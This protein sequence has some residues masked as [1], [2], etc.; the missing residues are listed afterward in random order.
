MKRGRKNKATVIVSVILAVVM[1]GASSFAVYAKWDEISA[2]IGLSNSAGTQTDMLSTLNS[3]ATEENPVLDETNKEAD[4][5]EDK[6]EVVIF[7]RP[8]YMRASYLV[9]GVDFL[10]GKAKNVAAIKEEIDKAISMTKGYQFNTI[11][12]PVNLNLMKYLPEDTSLQ[13]E[14]GSNFDILNYIT[15]KTAENEL[16]FYAVYDLKS[17][18]SE[19]GEFVTVKEITTEQINSIISQLSAFAKTYKP[20]GILLDNY[21]NEEVDTSYET[22]RKIGGGI[23]Y[24]NWLQEN[25]Y[26]LVKVAKETLKESNPAHQVGILA[27]GVW[28]NKQTN[29][30]GSDT[31]SSFE[32]LKNGWADTKKMIQNKLFDFAMVKNFGSLTN[33]NAPFET[34]AA[35]W[36]AIAKDANIPFYML[37]DAS[38]V[39]T[40]ETGWKNPDQL[41]RQAITVKKY[42]GF[43]GSAYLNLKAFG[44]NPKGSSQALLNYYAGET[45]ESYLFR[46]LTLY[47]PKQTNFVTYE[48]RVVFYGITDPNFE[49]V[50]NGKTMK[51]NAEGDFT[52]VV[53]L[54][55]GKNTITFEHKG[56]T[57]TYTITRRVV[58]LRDIA[59]LGSLRVTGESKIEINAT[60]YKGATVTA[61]LG[62]LSV[63]LQESAGIDESDSGSNYCTFTGLLT[64]PKETAVDQNLG[65]IIVTATWKGMTDSKQGAFVLV[66]KYS[67]PITGDMVEVSVEQAETYPIDVY[68]AFCDPTTF[69][70]AKGTIDYIVGDPI[71]YTYEGV[72][73][74]FVNLKSGKRVE[75]KEIRAIEN[76]NYSNN[77]IDSVT[78]RQNGQFTEV[79]FAN[80]WKVPYSLDFSPINYYSGYYVSSYQPTQM[81]ITIDYTDGICNLPSFATSPLFSNASWSL[82]TENGV[83]K[84]KLTVNLKKAGRFFGL[85]PIYDGNNLILR[86]NNPP[87]YQSA[88][89]Q[90]GATLVGTKIF[91]D[92]GHGA[93]ESCAVWQDKNGNWIREDKLNR[94]FTD[95]IEAILKSLGA[96][97]YKLDTTG[98]PISIFDRPLIAAQWKPNLYLSLHN[99][100]VTGNSS[101]RGSVTFY[102]N[103]FSKPL[104]NSL[105]NKINPVLA[106]GNYGDRFGR[107]RVIMHQNFPGS[108]IEFGFG[109]NQDELEN[110]KNPA[111]QQKFAEKVVEA[112]VEYCKNT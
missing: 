67:P 85:Y 65:N 83:S 55:I 71:K 7:K 111:I 13:N 30:S 80:K 31:K 8:D 41:S 66:K 15:E 39:C 91:L 45:D 52:E 23:G 63:N 110:L 68:N 98:S 36:D 92:P 96:T 18:V 34:V 106:S 62:G 105:Y 90:Y 22:Y 112:I 81:T 38:K 17:Y 40:D 46:E 86:F 28:A 49:V 5:K 56:K 26:A 21:Y 76:K 50:I 20:D 77:K 87:S 73:Y 59:P 108:L 37:H 3:D 64:M 16:Y 9:P 57:V 12:F 48:D 70:L 43:F 25:T 1:L 104:A 89:N 4:E 82:T 93:Q 101:A 88:G 44:E 103:T 35:W 109:T 19:T 54:D 29:K 102:Y 58:V 99:N 47:S 107:Y 84:A 75:Q 11:F 100:G 78:V 42:E 94:E 53:M 60:A 14:D 27:N 2:A 69:P 74:T 79:V 33:E 95:K 6:Q 24:E 10:T 32:A 61:R 97:V 51:I 72:E